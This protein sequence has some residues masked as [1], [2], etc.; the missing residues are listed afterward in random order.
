MENTEGSIE[1][2]AVV[3]T[4][5]GGVNKSTS[6]HTYPSTANAD[7]YE[8]VAL[9]ASD[10]GDNSKEIDTSLD[11]CLMTRQGFHLVGVRGTKDKKA[12]IWIRKNEGQEEIELTGNGKDVAWCVTTLD[13]S[14]LDLAFNE[15]ETE[16]YTGSHNNRST[17]KLKTPGGEGFTFAALFF[18]DPVELT[19]AGEGSDVFCKE[20]GHGDG[21]GFAVVVYQPGDAPSETIEVDIVDHLGDEGGEEYVTVAFK[22]N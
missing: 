4:H 10:G 3:Y 12:E 7:D 2:S 19:D 8:I 9:G 5:Q 1:G 22:S 13:G 15:F 21:D 17:A 6:T 18:D 16:V 14:N 11:A 20:W